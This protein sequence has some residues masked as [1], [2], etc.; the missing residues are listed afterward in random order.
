MNNENLT[1]GSPDPLKY[2]QNVFIRSCMDI[3]LKNTTIEEINEIIKLLKLKN[4][5][6]Y[7]EISPKF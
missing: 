6:G 7:D 2:L 3:K 4:S 1:S 5:N